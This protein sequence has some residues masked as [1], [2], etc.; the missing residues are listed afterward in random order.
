M[1]KINAVRIINLN[2]NNNAIRVDDETFRFDGDSTLLSLRNGGGKSVL[3]QMFAAPFVH[4]RY[5]DA[6]DRPFGSYFTT[7]KP[8]F[9]LVEWKLDGDAGFVT[10]GMMVRKR[11]EISE[12]ESAQ[13]EELEIINY[14]YEYRDRDPYDIQNLP[15]IEETEAGKRL[16]GFSASKKLFEDLKKEKK[17]NFDWY[18]M[19]IA[20]QS[21]QYFNRLT[22]F[23]IYY[24]EWE[25]II[26][27]VNLKESG[28][29]ELFTDAKDERGLVEKWFLDAV[30]NKLN[31]DT[32]R[33]GEFG[34]ILYKYIGQYKENKSKIERRDIILRFKEE[35][36]AVRERARALKEALAVRTDLEN[37]LANLRTALAGLSDSEDLRRK[38]IEAKIE[39]IER[40]IRE[41]LYEE[42]SCG[43]YQLID[44]KEELEEQR[45]AKEAAAEAAHE[46]YTEAAHQYD[47]QFCANLYD[48]YVQAESAVLEADNKLEVIRAKSADTA[49]ERDN[50]GYTLRL[51]YEKE[52]GRFEEK[53]RELSDRLAREQERIDSLA[54]LVSEKQ[55]SQNRLSEESGV[56]KQKLASYDMA[57]QEYNAGCREPLQRNILGEYEPG[58][59]DVLSDRLKKQAEGVKRQL[60]NLNKSREE[61]EEKEKSCTRRL[62]DGQKQA[63]I[64]E[65]DEVSAVGE[66]SGLEDQ[67][68]VRKT[69]L[70]YVGL[71]EDRLFDTPAVLDAFRRKTDGQKA[72]IRE[73]EEEYAGILKE[74][75]KLKSGKVL[76]LPDD[77][78]EAFEEAGLRYLYGMEWL[79]RSEQSA[80]EK[81]RLVDQN[82][83]LPYSII[84]TE[85]DFNELTGRELPVFTNFPIP[86]IKRE[87]LEK[88]VS[89]TQGSVVTFGRVNF[90]VVFNKE[91]L[92]EESLQKMLALKSEMLAGL[93]ETLDRRR[94][95]LAFLTEKYDILRFQTLTGE[96]Y[97][98]AKKNR[99]I[100]AEKRE[101]LNRELTGARQ[102]LEELRKEGKRLETQIQAA[103]RGLRELSAQGVLAE[104][105][106]K[107]YADY[108]D[109]RRDFGRNEEERRK[110]AEEIVQNGAERKKA[111]AVRDSLSAE[112]LYASGDLERIK[113]KAA[114]FSRYQ[115]GEAIKKDIEDIE[116]RFDVLTREINEEQKTLEEQQEKAMALF[117]KREADLTRRAD[118]LGV[119]ETEYKYTKYDSFV[120]EELDG[121]KTRLSETEKMF[122]KE[123]ADLEKMIAVRESEL[124]A[125]RRQIAEKTGNEETK[126]R[127]QIVDLEF[128]KR[129]A[130]KANQR[131]QEKRD[132]EAV[133]ARLL[134][135][136]QNLSALAEYENLSVTEPYE[137]GV[138]LSECGREELNSL[139]GKLKRD[140]R[141]QGEEIGRKRQELSETLSGV[142]EQKQFADDFWANPLKTLYG[143][144]E[145]PDSVLEQL[146]TITRS[147]DSLM[148]K[149]AVDI[150]IIEKEKEK[151]IDI[152]LEYICDVHRNL[153]KID[154]NSTITIR[155]K[156]VKM[157]RIRLP[158]WEEQEA[159]YRGKLVDFVEELTE[160]G[161]KG[162]E[163]NENIE[164]MIGARVTTKNLYDTVAG[165]GNIEI[166]L[167]KI[168]AER[169]YPI[170]WAEVARNSG[171]EG[172]LSAFVV[173]SSLLSYMRREDT[174]IF[175]EHEEGKVLVMDN[176]FAQTNASHLLKPLMDIAK[177]SNTQLICL[178]GLG[179]ESIYSR[180]DNIYV[181]N[182]IPSGLRRG[183]T[184]LKG[185]H[186]KGEETEQEEMTSARIEVRDM[187]QMEFDFWM[188]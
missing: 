8:T 177:K 165:I 135:Y 51:H 46:E 171:G 36:A 114:A 29:S 144:K 127:D 11:Q 109:H 63:G 73:K 125:K 82:P 26:K 170:S 91:L 130:V 107:K 150:A 6:K 77:M 154:R 160:S 44:A 108:L 174:D 21:R 32:S 176:P 156:P 45:D 35:T 105:L 133:C 115:S 88:P 181:L 53:I 27:K 93:L 9:L 128:A 22:E 40:E 148:E 119:R 120:E 184:Y 134:L 87:E 48:E 169:E 14:I 182:L 162:L 58:M 185:E 23:R 161:L 159:V 85:R 111:E 102:E 137:F 55:K 49:P 131:E 19:G 94:E 12:E 96:A 122:R 59:F 62:E 43:I 152:L 81:R 143:L 179:G 172:F 24:R 173:L 180:F 86:I 69:F 138:N 54:K 95:E 167:Y 52:R 2:Y 132:L 83:F 84:L 168:E 103:D 187:D 25:A 42:L 188:E 28:L 164:E 163:K 20:S 38:D 37:R 99:L 67:I 70:K 155:E 112:R 140:Y 141:N 149:L 39:E 104:R 18:D 60:L 15:V 16:K 74:Y 3:V 56:L 17:G 92:N 124:S 123:Q 113:E 117:R 50:L 13:A 34:G 100:L 186:L 97:E 147:F 57:E 65:R 31:K 5:R 146:D 175:G 145:N 136:Q 98:A 78:K 33:I 178:T 101:A 61:A 71:E 4:K 106:R 66:I 153:E 10:T 68:A 118:R 116:A 126:A 90:Y 79:R 72:A 7:N 121:K 183:M 110:L 129:R 139:Q 41:I 75:E 142:L 30:E 47:I 64:L 89:G 1:S 166:R 76:E 157:L 158:K 151:A 80:D